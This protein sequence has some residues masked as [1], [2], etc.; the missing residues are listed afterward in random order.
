MKDEM[1]L[2]IYQHTPSSVS[3]HPRTVL[4]ASGVC[5]S[6]ALNR[7]LRGEL[8]WVQGQRW[9]WEVGMRCWEWL[10][11]ILCAELD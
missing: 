7:G 10:R 6:R 4:V 11:K 2:G 3:L 9:H 8:W 1:D 5:T